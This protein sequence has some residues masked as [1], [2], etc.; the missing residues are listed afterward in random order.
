MTMHRDRPA[1]AV[2]GLLAALACSIAPVGASNPGDLEARAQR[3]EGQL[4]APCCGANTLAD[5]DSGPAQQMKREI[6]E[7]LASGE[8][9]EAILAR[10]ISQHG[11][12]ILSTP[13]GTGFNLVAYLLPTLALVLGP[14]LLWRRLRHAPAPVPAVA[15]G[16]GVTPRVPTAPADALEESYRE[17]LA[18][19]LRE[20]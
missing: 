4:M 15:G 8:N 10:Y 2:L 6:R 12:T 14:L 7:L 20:G 16:P 1:F 11:E 13:P 5:H 9:E 18:R 3:L 17:R 19:E